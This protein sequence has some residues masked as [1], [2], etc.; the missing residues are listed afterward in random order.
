[1]LLFNKEGKK[2][3][4]ML[5]KYFSDVLAVKSLFFPYLFI[6]SARNPE[7]HPQLMQLGGGGMLIRG[8]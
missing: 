1:M 5:I 3:K 6:L 8:H 4:E 2:K 7:R